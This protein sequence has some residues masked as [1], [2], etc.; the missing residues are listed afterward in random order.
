MEHRTYEH[1][2]HGHGHGAGDAQ[3][4]VLDLDAEVLADQL[5]SIVDRLPLRT[6]P[7]EIVDLGAG[8]GTGTLALLRRFPDAHVTAVDSSV[9][10]LQ[11]LAEKVASGRVTTVEADLDGA[12]PAL[13]PADLVWASAS[14]HHVAD[15]DLVLRRLRDVLTP[16][17]LLAVVELAGMPR[18]LP[19]DAAAGRLE[20]RLHA[21]ADRRMA[22]HMPHRGADWGVLVATAGYT[23]EDR[24]TVAVDERRPDDDAVRRY[25]G[26]VLRRMRDTFADDLPPDDLPTDD[27]AALDELLDDSRPD[28]IARRTDL[29]VRTERTL[30]A[31]RP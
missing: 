24:H 8:T 19:D 5:A 27:L 23:V 20:A 28:G 25:A 17:G 22:E 18:F 15:P 16:G 21:A 13:G 12:W 2:Q 31:A 30:W 4:E 7:A 11:R 3:A 1:A 29:V 26:I 9:A 10:H 14:L 6:P